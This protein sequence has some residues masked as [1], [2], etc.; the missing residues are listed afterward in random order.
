VTTETRTR[1]LFRFHWKS[2]PPN[3]AWAYTAEEAANRIGIGAGAL[4]ALDYWEVVEAAQP[5]VSHPARRRVPPAQPRS[6]HPREE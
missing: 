1:R 4:A 3:E 6:T 5:E 2:G